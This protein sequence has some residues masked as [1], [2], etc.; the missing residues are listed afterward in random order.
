MELD[1]EQKQALF[2]K[3][4]TYVYWI[5][6]YLLIVAYFFGRSMVSDLPPWISIAWNIIV[7]EMIDFILASWAICM[8]LIFIIFKY[9]SVKC[10]EKKQGMPYYTWDWGRHRLYQKKPAFYAIIL[11]AIIEFILN[12]MKII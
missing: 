2:D 9:V 4:M 3:W 11:I 12:I 7:S 1:E 8:L 10:R 6:A 5:I